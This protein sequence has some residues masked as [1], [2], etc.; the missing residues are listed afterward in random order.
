MLLHTAR[1]QADHPYPIALLHGPVVLVLQAAD[2][3]LP[4]LPWQD[5]A[6]ALQP[7]P[8]DPLLYRIPSAPAAVVRPYYAI[9]EG[10]PYFIAL[11]PAMRNRISYRAVRVSPNWNDTGSSRFINI[12][13]ATATV[14]FAG[15]GIR[16][17]GYRY[18]DGG[19]GEVRIDGKLVATVDQYGPGRDLPFDWRATG[20]PNGKHTLTI[21]LLADKA[22]ASRD[23]YLSFTGFEILE[24]QE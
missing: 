8:D 13:G 16:W 14:D 6:A 10:E 23:R 22:P 18:D 11:D 17:L 21:T 2:T 20:L 4:Q 5:L 7:A 9:K 15:N 24:S 19:R 3:R 12:V 1:F